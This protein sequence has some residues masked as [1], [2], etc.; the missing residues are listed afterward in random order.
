MSV[1]HSVPRRDDE[2]ESEAPVPPDGGWGWLVVFGSFMIHVISKSQ[3][4]LLYCSNVA[5]LRS[6]FRV[7]KDDQRGPLLSVYV[8]DIQSPA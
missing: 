8:T 4:Y 3:L 7:F 6:C 5:M 2:E 1:G